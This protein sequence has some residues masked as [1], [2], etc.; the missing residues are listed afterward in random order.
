MPYFSYPVQFQKDQAKIPALL[1]FGSEINVIN[2]AYTAKLSLK[3]RAINVRAQN[4]ASS[5]FKTFEMVL[6]SFQIKN[7]VEKAPFF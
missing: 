5:T 4:I 2:P 1:D 3:V 6:A 7:M